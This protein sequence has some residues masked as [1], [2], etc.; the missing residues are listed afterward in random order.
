MTYDTLF[1]KYLRIKEVRYQDAWKWNPPF[2]KHLILHKEVPYSISDSMKFPYTFG[3]D[4]SGGRGQTAGISSNRCRHKKQLFC[5]GLSFFYAVVATF[6]VD[7]S[8]ASIILKQLVTAIFSV[9]DEI[10]ILFLTDLAVQTL[11]KCA[12][13]PS[14]QF[15]AEE[16]SIAV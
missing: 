10:L 8:S 11:S 6:D 15:G 7:G 4:G 3:C 13:E 5:F 14:V 12:E 2:F 1:E 16:G 9:A